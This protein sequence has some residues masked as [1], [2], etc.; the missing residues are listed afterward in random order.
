MGKSEVAKVFMS[1]G[2]PVFDSD[3]E[4]HRLYDSQEGATCWHP[5]RPLPSATARSTA[6]R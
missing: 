2:I 3:R 5:L 1:E 6:R 4:V